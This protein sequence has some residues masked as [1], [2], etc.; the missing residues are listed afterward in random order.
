MITFIGRHGSQL[1]FTSDH[2]GVVVDTE[3]NMV[4]ESGTPE[5][6]FSS[7]A[8]DRSNLTVDQNYLALA[9]LSLNTLDAKSITAAAGRMYT[10][11]KA[12]Q[13]EAKKA[14]EWRKEHKRGGTPVGLNTARILAKGGQIGLQKVRHIAKYF[15][16]HEVDKKGKGWKPGQ[17][18]FPSNGRIAWALWGGDAAWRWAADIVKHADPKAMKA[19]GYLMKQSP[20]DPF[21]NAFDLDETYGPEFMA[22]VCLDG[23]GLDRLYKVDIDGQVYVWDNDCWEDMGNVDNDVWDYD[24][25]LDFEDDG[26]EKSHILID[27]SSAVMIAAR[28]SNNPFGKVSVFDLD[29]DEAMLAAR[30]IPEEDWEMIDLGMV[31]AGEGGMGAPGYTSKERSANVAKQPRS[32]GGRFGSKGSSGNTAGKQTVSSQQGVTPQGAQAAKGKPGGISLEEQ[33]KRAESGLP[34]QEILEGP[35]DTSGILGEPRTPIDR[36]NAR[37]SGTLPAMTKEDLHQVLYDFPAWV[38]SQRASYTPGDY[39]TP[40]TSAG[41]EKEEKEVEAYEHPLLKK[42]RAT[43]Q[44]EEVQPASDNSWASPVV[45]SAMVAAPTTPSEIAEAQKPASDPKV[46]TQKDEAK[47]EGAPKNSPKPSDPG[48]PVQLTPETSDVQPLYFAVVAPDD[49]QAV[50]DLISMVPASSVSTAPMVYRRLDKKWVRDEKTLADLKSA[51]PPPVVP[52]DSATLNDVLKQI[53]GITAS[54]AYLQHQMMVL[55]GP[56]E[57]ILVAAGGLDRNRG[58]AEQLRRYWA[59]GKGAAKIRWGTP[60]DW[61]RCVRHLSKYMGVRAKGY[62]QLRHKEALGIYTATH[63]KRDRQISGKKNFSNQEFMMEEVWTE[64]TGTPTKIT[65]KDM[66]MPIDDIMREQDDVY[67]HEWTPEPEIEK[68][69]NDEAC[70]KAMTA[71]GGLDR[72]RGNAEELRRYW[73]VGKG[74]AKIRWNTKGDWTRC[75]RQLE[76]YLGPRAKGYCALRHKEMT[77][78]WTGDKRHRELYGRKGRS[79]NKAFFSSDVLKSSEMVIDSVALVARSNNARQ[80]LG[81]LAGGSSAMHTSGSSFRI[82]LVIPEGRETGD[83][84]TFRKGSIT[85]RELPLPLLWQVRTS[86]GHNGSVVVGRIDRMERTED[87]IG[88]A[89][90]VFD[91]GEYGR[92]AERLVRNGFIRGVSADMDQFEAEEEKKSSKSKTENDIDIDDDKKVGGDKLTINKA[93]VMAVTM[94]PKPAFQECKIF[95]VEEEENPQEENMIPQ[96]GIYAEDLDSLD[97]SALV[98]CAVVAGAIPVVPPAEW[99]NNPKLSKPTPITVTDDG[100]VYGHIAAWNV[101]HIGLVAGTKPPRSKSNYSYFH[102]GVIRT[103]NGKDVPVGQLTLAGGHAPLEASAL[104]AVKHYDDTASAIADVHAGEDAHG[105]WVA[106]GLRPSATPEQIRALRA[107]APSG[108]WRPIRGSLELVAVCQVN[109][110]GF[111]IARARVASGAVLALVAAGA[112]PLAELK[113]SQLYGPEALAAAA[114]AKFDELRAERAAVFAAKSAELSNKIHGYVDALAITKAE[115]DIAAKK[116]QALPDGSYPIRNEEDLKN[117]IQ[118]FGR[119]KE[120]ERGRVRRHIMRRAK[121]LGKSDLIP[122]KWTKQH[123]AST[124]ES[125]TASTEPN[126]LRARVA[127]AVEALGKANA[128]GPANPLPTAPVKS[129]E[130]I[131]TEPKDKPVMEKKSEDEK[132]LTPKQIEQKVVEEVKKEADPYAQAGDKYVPGKN[133]PRDEYGKFRKV[134]ARLKLNLGVAGLERVARK[135][136]AAEGYTEIGD[137]GTA[138]KAASDLIDTVDRLDTGAL[139]AESLENIRSTTK[140]LGQTI[141]NLPLPFKDPNAKLRYSDLPP[142]LKDLLDDM[143]SR[144]EQKIGSKDAAIAT[145]EIRSF[146]SGSKLFGQ[147]DISREFNKLLRLLT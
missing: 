112:R 40:M 116:R 25:E 139:N 130:P 94:V 61:K 13:A 82:P 140:E 117:A 19:D 128:V 79:S 14:L 131:G 55:W 114:K 5:T 45:A 58:N 70:I 75:V 126:E 68:L 141:A 145:Q 81:L 83:G 66:L 39:K 12:A 32:A 54:A 135:V 144:V 107:S 37:I 17:D 86:D 103:A 118:A 99:F 132:R 11:P 63:A 52:L 56:R 27:P 59:H 108:D 137:Y 80:R 106:G 125:I 115:R 24:N 121:A 76:K 16:R 26:I 22:R 101:D 49:P 51:T 105:I 100:R 47:P 90:G 28:L 134:L 6:L 92:E 20:V 78:M 48:K 111:P 1:L 133:Q 98:A 21:K 72:N 123:V 57:E 93:R 8:W 69:L 87:G 30:S 113:A 124:S 122:E 147:S 67:D 96:D 7:R 88:N 89:V 44:R 33:R 85:M 50:L 18:N 95:L 142:V 31:A 97:N 53:D 64:N 65:D 2:H 136:S 42:W 34:P 4:V 143:T 127:A 146:K 29:E 91:T 60:G 9:N 138:A 120:E 104:D 23:S 74:G 119:A 35:L 10:I 38:Q 46:E 73:T 102:T 36:P 43:K 110:P 109:V 71:A 77:G 41:D 15:P 3:F 62:C 84:R 129:E